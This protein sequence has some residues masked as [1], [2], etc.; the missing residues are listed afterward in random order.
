MEKNVL[1]KS[2][3]TFTNMLNKY[4]FTDTNTEFLCYSDNEIKFPEDIPI[5]CLEEN[6]DPSKNGDLPILHFEEL[7][8]RAIYQKTR[9]PD[10]IL[11]EHNCDT[12]NKLSASYFLIKNKSLNKPKQVRD[13]IEK[14]YGDIVSYIGSVGNKS[15]SDS[16][17]SEG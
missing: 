7:M 2:C 12:F 17:E 16:E 14:R 13:L 8:I 15:T 11:A 5:E 3:K 4:K 6:S 1:V 10:K 9:T